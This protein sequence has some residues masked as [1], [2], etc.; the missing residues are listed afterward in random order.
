VTNRYRGSRIIGML[1]AGGSVSWRYQA[2]STQT[3]L[4]EK[5]WLT[6]PRS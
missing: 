2:Y 3:D 5:A 1:A 6:K 4:T